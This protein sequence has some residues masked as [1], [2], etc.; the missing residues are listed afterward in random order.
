MNTRMTMKY[1]LRIA[2]EIGKA[3]TCKIPVGCILVHKQMIVGM[4]YVGSTHGDDH[5]DEH[6]HIEIPA[7]YRGG[8]DRLSCVRTI[9]A[10]MNAILK[11]TVRGSKDGG[12]IDC[13]STHQPCLECT[14]TLLQIGAR[15]VFYVEEYVDERRDLFLQK[16]RGPSL[17]SI[18][19]DLAEGE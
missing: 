9:H 16:Y 8:V 17:Q 12:W 15:R 3:S 14:K 18:K 7:P 5:C 13:Y 1:W 4:G 2:F 19:V 6:D 11:C 10:E